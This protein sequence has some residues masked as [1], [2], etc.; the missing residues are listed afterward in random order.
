LKGALLVLEGASEGVGRSVGLGALECREAHDRRSLK[1]EGRFRSR[2]RLKKE[3]E[4]GG[5]G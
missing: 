3:G 2:S 5:G 1:V 4:T